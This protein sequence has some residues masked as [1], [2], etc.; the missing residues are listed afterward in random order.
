MKTKR[1]DLG[2]HVSSLSNY[3]RHLENEHIIEK[4]KKIAKNANTQKNKIVKTK[5]IKEFFSKTNNNDTSSQTSNN[6][7]DVN[8]SGEC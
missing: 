1:Q 4:T 6:N 3:I 8:K 7:C 5:T 2:C